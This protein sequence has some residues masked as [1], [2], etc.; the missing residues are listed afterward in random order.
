MSRSRSYREKQKAKR[1]KKLK[2]LLKILWTRWTDADLDKYVCRN[3]GVWHCKCDWCLGEDK[4]KKLKRIHEKE[5]VIWAKYIEFD[6]EDTKRAL[7]YN[8]EKKNEE[9]VQ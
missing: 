2:N 6:K 4:K 3:K 1:R 8:K 7:D 5:M 9:Q